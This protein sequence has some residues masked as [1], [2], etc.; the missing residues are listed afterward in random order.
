MTLVTIY[1]DSNVIVA[2]ELDDEKQH[3]ESR[4]FMQR[5]LGTREPDTYYV[6]SVFT[7]LELASAMIR[8]TQSEDRALALLY[9]I[10]NSW[11]K[12]IRPVSPLPTKQFTSFTALIDSLIDTTM[13]FQTRSADT[14]HAQSVY[15]YDF[16]YLVTWNA[17]D[18][19]HLKK[20]MTGLTILNPRE[21]HIL[22]SDWAEARRR[23][24]HHAKVRVKHMLSRTSSLRK[25]D[26]PSSN[27][28]T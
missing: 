15:I 3:A 11:K 5:V 22:L 8:R 6:T 19:V 25:L 23:G 24:V 10:R 2:S 4:E 20:T 14:I 17:K 26:A 21:M 12:S 13:K 28:T 1:I 9:K 7:F 27:Q 18:F 16:D